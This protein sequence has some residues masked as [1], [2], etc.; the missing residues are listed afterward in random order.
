MIEDEGK[1]SEKMSKSLG[2][3]YNL[4]DVRHRGFRPSALRYL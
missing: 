4:E 2:N 3:V 1:S